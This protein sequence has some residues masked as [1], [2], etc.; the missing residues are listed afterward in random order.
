MSKV[1]YFTFP[2]VLL[3]SA[4]DD[5]TETLNNIILY[6]LYQYADALKDTTGLDF[7]NCYEQA[8]TYFD[9]QK[10]NIKTV[11]DKS[12][13]LYDSL[14]NGLPKPMT[15]VNRDVIFDYRANKANK[16]E[17][18]I[19]CLCGFAAIKSILGKKSHSKI[20]NEYFLARTFGF[21]KVE[22]MQN[23]PL[24]PMLEKY[25]KRYHLNKVKDELKAS[26]G[27]K[28]Y[29]RNTRGFYASISMDYESLVFQVEKNRKSRIR[30]ERK[31]DED[32]IQ[33]RVLDRL[34]RK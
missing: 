22:D 20:T 33:K 28:L 13:A 9:L 19:I 4:H 11:L 8:F 26:W 10:K 5:L 32:E 3:K 7:E 31:A 34:K 14:D 6:G 24:S 27:V 1:K 25:A 21:A 17:F 23:S 2:V 12:V 18:E 29:G 15:S 16:S 30:Q